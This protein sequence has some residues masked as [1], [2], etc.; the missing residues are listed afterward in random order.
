[1]KSK[2]IDF[3]LINFLAQF[4]VFSLLETFITEVDYA[5]V[6]S[7]FKQFNLRFTP[8]VKDNVFGR[9]V[10]GSLIGI[11]LN[12]KVVNLLNFEMLNGFVSVEISLKQDLKAVIVPV[13]LNCNSWNRDFL[14]LSNVI[15]SNPGK[16]FIIIGDINARIANKQEV[17]GNLIDDCNR[18]S[19]VRNSKDTIL[20]S[21][22]KKYLEFCDN[23]GQI[24]LN[25][26]SVSDKDGEY[27]FISSVGSSVID[28]CSVSVNCLEYVRDFKVCSY[29]GSDHLPIQLDLNINF[30]VVEE[31]AEIC[32]LLPKLLWTNMDDKYFKSNLNI[33][34]NKRGIVNTVQSRV[35]KITLAIKAASYCNSGPSSNGTKKG[36]VGKKPWF[37]R[38]CELARNKSMRT[39]NLYRKYGTPYLK[40]VYL[41]LSRDYKNILKA[42]QEEYNKTIVNQLRNVRYTKQFWKFAN[43]FKSGTRYVGGNIKVTD[44]VKHFRALLNPLTEARP[45]LYAEPFIRVECLD[46]NIEM[47]EIRRVLMLAKN[48]KA[49]G[50][51]RIPYEFYKQGSAELW[52]ELLDLFNFILDTGQVPES[53]KKSIV[54][55]LYKKGDVNQVSNYRGI[56][57]MDSLA[58]IFTGVIL[59]RLEK[60]VNDNNILS[61]YQAGFRRG[62]STVD[63]IFVLTSLIHLKLS[64]K[65]GKLYCFFVDFSAAF[66]RIDRHALFYKLFNLGI[67]SKIM[68]VLRNLYDGT[69]A[70][71]WCRDGLSETFSTQKGVRQGCLLSP[72]LFSLFMD[73]LSDALEGGVRVG[74]TRVKVLLYADDIVLVSESPVGLQY[75]I[76]ML[77]KYCN[78]WSLK[79]NLEKSKIMVFRKGGKRAR[80][81]SW[82]YDGKRIEVVNNYKYLGVLLTSSLSFQSHLAQR[83]TMSKNS[84]NSIWNRFLGHNKITLSAKFECFNMVVRSIMCYGAQVWGFKEYDVVENL[85]KFFVKRI[86]SLPQNTPDYMIYL[87]TGQEKLFLFNFKLHIN[88]LGKVFQMSQNRLP[89]VLAQEVVRRKVYWFRELQILA[90]RHGI[91]IDVDAGEGW[92]EQ[93]PAV[94]EA[95]RRDSRQQLLR[96]ALGSRYHSIYR[97][98][99]LELGRKA[100]F[101]DD[102]DIKTIR[103][104]FKCRGE[105]LYLNY[106]PWL[107]DQRQLCSL[108]NMAVN[109]DVFHFI[110]QCPILAE[111]RLIWFNLKEMHRDRFI[112][113]LNGDNWIR[114][115]KYAQHAWKVRWEMVQEFNY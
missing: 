110:A 42:K 64:V 112:Q 83:L 49:P 95:V 70:A 37:D 28:L 39:L 94:L 4:D 23:N 99:D 114:L 46:K 5:L 41:D 57:F 22:G 55:P 51:D 101:R 16:S 74:G 44:W 15:D 24:V 87:E 61:E 7:Y 63:N 68:R 76:N 53:F 107:P 9:A 108:C 85:L 2:I 106:K 36:T 104:V 12:S 14:Q 97:S 92:W 98:L 1:M 113:V 91:V 66:D 43:S 17:D 8:A 111:V 40:K 72:L 45:V 58:K 96:A 82:K 81:E 26:R 80:N 73:D 71:V 52:V 34:L 78:V 38:E 19:R 33:Q 67:S 89:N 35:D 88:Y 65:R 6:V 75:M 21:N 29:V 84:I 48:D 100:Y 50:P 62:Y 105:L 77:E 10:G 56:S 102:L 109:E 20:N 59:N 79:V 47:V 11:N 90:G 13:Y 32:P 27:S 60:W 86:L 69:G 54:F 31:N 93:L 25:G 103:W 30:K 115:A 18:I 3:T